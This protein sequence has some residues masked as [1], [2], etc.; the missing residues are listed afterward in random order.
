MILQNATDQ[1]WQ[2]VAKFV[3]NAFDDNVLDVMTSVVQQLVGKSQALYAQLRFQLGE[4]VRRR[5]GGQSA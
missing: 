2:L 1:G 4:F 5:S 3:H